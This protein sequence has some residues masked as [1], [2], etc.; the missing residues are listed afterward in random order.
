[1]ILGG[2][3]CLVLSYAIAQISSNLAI[4]HADEGSLEDDLAHN[5]ENL[6]S[7][8][9]TLTLSELQYLPD[10]GSH[11]WRNRTQIGIENATFCVLVRNSELQEFLKT[12]REIEDRFNKNYRYPWTFLNDV[13]FTDEFK[14]LTTG[15]AS[16]N[17]EYGLVPKEMWSL[18]DFIDENLFEDTRMDYEQRNVIYGSSV[19]YRHM[20]RFNSGFFFRH[21][22]MLKYDWYWRV[23]P[24]T[25]FY[26]DQRYDPF[27]FMRENNK[28]YGFVITIPE[29]EE[30]IPTL[31][32]TTEQYFKENP[33]VLAPEN[34]VKFITDKSTV[35]PGDIVITST[36]DY[37]LCHF[38]SNFEIANLN[39]FRSDKYIRYFEH[40]DR[41]GGFFYER[42]GDAPVHTIAVAMMLNRSEIHHFADM[43]YRHIPYYRCPHDE[44]SY[45]TGRCLCDE[46]PETNVDFLPYSCLP[47]WWLH[48]G[49]HFLYKYND[50]I[51]LM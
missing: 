26:C 31:W 35:R 47:K 36:S 19:S 2:A 18:P 34:A 8:D 42:W 6:K 21:E 10:I 51:L 25:R 7:F 27:T 16:G 12:M 22:L 46:D 41:R 20:C 4:I 5:K 32:E 23:E 30:T 39:F 38:W 3:V 40:L 24:G 37:N 11:P 50:Q 13:P 9:E 1:M 28:T 49:R 14:R 29:Y 15:M 44:A 48:G 33:E 45:T 43:G 17:V